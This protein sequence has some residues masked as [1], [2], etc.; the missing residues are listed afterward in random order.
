MNKRPRDDHSFASA[1]KRQYGAGTPYPHHPPSSL[2]HH[3]PSRHRGE[4]SCRG[5]I[6]WLTRVWCLSGRRR[7]WPAAGL[8]G[9]AEQRAAGGRPLQR[10]VQ[11][12]TRGTREQPHHPPQEAQQLGGSQFSLL[13]YRTVPG[14]LIKMGDP[15]CLI[16]PVSN[17][18]DGVTVQF[19]CLDRSRVFWS[20]C[21]HARVTAF[22]ILLAGRLV[23][24][25]RCLA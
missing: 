6:W 19:V 21:M 11:P 4:A 16:H 17:C 7:V 15:W 1:P 3:C 14:F 20:S 8:L 12:D 10:A 23:A 2:A 22:L 13:P 5:R 18:T 25:C 9:R 24:C